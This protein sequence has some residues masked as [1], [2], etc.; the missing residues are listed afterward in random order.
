M[1]TVMRLAIAGIGILALAL[2][3]CS[4]APG[5]GGDG[6]PDVGNGAATAG[7]AFTYSYG[8]T[9][10]ARS[11]AT[12][13]E[14]HAA[15]CEALGSGRCRIT[16][17]GYTVDRAGTVS[18]DL[19]VRV[20]APIARRFAREAVTAAEQ[21]GA[22]LT[23]AHIGGDD[24]SLAQTAATRQSE[25]ATV[26]LTRIDR[27]L[28]R[29]DLPAA[30]RAELRSQRAAETQAARTAAA[31]QTQS[32][33]SIATAPVAFHYEAGR[34]SGLLNSLRDSGDT[35]IASATATVTAIT[36]LVA[37]LGPPLLSLAVV[38]WLWLWLG[39]PLWR[40]IAATMRARTDEPA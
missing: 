4:K 2:T 28:A 13:Q 37:M 9:L 20:A 21:A 22:T 39:A 24:V 5:G 8:L 29:P 11:I 23:G 16:G 40:R 14:A 32:A 30:E 6:G 31:T 36:W 7:L 33:A 35:A 26:E 38:A 25:E 27:A 15:A 18:A 3:G 19:S 17:L 34:G 1:G 12:V 10:P